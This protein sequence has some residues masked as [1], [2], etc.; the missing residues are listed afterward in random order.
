M[1]HFAA[2]AEVEKPENLTSKAFRRGAAIW[3]LQQKN[4][5]AQ[6]LEA[7]GWR[8]SAFLHYVLR[9]EV[10]EMLLFSELAVVSDDEDG[11]EPPLTKATA[12][13]AKR[14]VKR[15]VE[16]VVGQAPISKYLRPRPNPGE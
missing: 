1:R 16:L 2:L 11:Q 10:D 15:S 6:V 12:I 14:T 4:P 8:S 3:M 5:L 7:G 9:E 13:M